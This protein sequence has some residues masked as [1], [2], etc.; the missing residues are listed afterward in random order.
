[1]NNKWITLGILSII[2]TIVLF[3]LDIKLLVAILIALVIFYDKYLFG[4]ITKYIPLLNLDKELSNMSILLAAHYFGVLY[5]LTI[6][7]INLILLFLHKEIRNAWHI[8]DFIVKGVSVLV[9]VF[10]LGSNNIFAEIPYIIFIA[11]A[12]SFLIRQVIL[13]FGFDDR[14]ILSYIQDVVA[15]L[16]YFALFN[17]LRIV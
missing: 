12:A 7:V 3:V 15:L 6:M 4:I 1:M 13:Q 16:I 14:T 8:T 11:I 10:L 5:G 9:M 17:L 2:C